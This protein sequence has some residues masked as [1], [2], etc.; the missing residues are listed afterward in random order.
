M[1]DPAAGSWS[2]VQAYS[3]SNT[4]SWTNTAPAGDYF[5]GVHARDLASSAPFE[6][7]AGIPYT[8][9]P[10]PCTA[11]SL[12]ALPASPQP[13]G[14]QVDVTASGTCPNA[15][16]SYEFWARWQGSSTWQMLQAYSTSNTWTWSTTGKAPGAYR[17]A[18]WVRDAS[19]AGA[20]S[21]G[22]GSWAL[23]SKP[24]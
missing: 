8:L 5:V 24:R 7:F 21:N 20:Y 10:T 19:S 16:P 4:F 6:S 12:T 2:I 22:S 1:L 13:S 14:T 11:V 3:G 9:T 17:V 18:V 23:A 15:N